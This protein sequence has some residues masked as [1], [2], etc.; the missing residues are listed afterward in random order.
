MKRD[1]PNDNNRRD[2]DQVQRV[3]IQQAYHGPGKKVAETELKVEEIACALALFASLNQLTKDI[4]WNVY[5][6]AIKVENDQI[7]GALVTYYWNQNLTESSPEPNQ[8]QA[9]R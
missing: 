8:P 4:K 3:V 1:S 7:V 5:D 6:I 2:S 9:A